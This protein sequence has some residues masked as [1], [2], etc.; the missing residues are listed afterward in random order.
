M[1]T[2]HNL[3]SNVLS[4]FCTGCANNVAHELAEDCSKPETSHIKIIEPIMLKNCL[5]YYS[6]PYSSGNQRL[7]SFSSIYNCI[8]MT[9]DRVNRDQG[10]RPYAYL[11]SQI[12][13]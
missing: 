2:E 13:R 6:G 4:F 7:N 5:S 12:D 10:S 3:F 9:L 8:G 11:R 1:P